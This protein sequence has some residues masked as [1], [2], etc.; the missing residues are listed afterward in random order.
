M[1]DMLDDYSASKQFKL[2]KSEITFLTISSNLLASGSK[3]TNILIWDI[4][5]QEVLYR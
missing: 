4:I 3:D 1:Y 5:G 2:H